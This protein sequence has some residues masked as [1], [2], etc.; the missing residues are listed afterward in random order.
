[1]PGPPYE[2][3]AQSRR[4]Y[5][6]GSSLG[7]RCRPAV[8]ASGAGQRCRPAVPASGAGQRCRPAVPARL[9]R[10][11]ASPRPSA[12]RQR[13]GAAG[14]RCWGHRTS[15][16]HTSQKLPIA[17]AMPA[18]R[19][20]QCP[21]TPGAAARR[22]R[23]LLECWAP[24]RGPPERMQIESKLVAHWVSM[25]PLGTVRHLFV[26]KETS[27]VAVQ[28]VSP[29]PG[30]LALPGRP[31]RPGRPALPGRPAR[32]GRGGPP[33]PVDPRDSNTTDLPTELLDW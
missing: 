20:R 19:P 33:S 22:A 6:R 30:R 2:Q 4:H 16:R 15:P 13:P 11:P 29:S 14:A 25:A 28:D 32:P 24:P 8:P 31:A 10:L 3:A 12:A 23:D 18:P 26:G 7:Q 27:Q 21:V 5:A 9:Q 1:M 17:C